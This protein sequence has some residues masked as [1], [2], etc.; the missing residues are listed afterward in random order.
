VGGDRTG[1][2]R[3]GA[4][5]DIRRHA[6]RPHAVGR[7]PL[8]PRRT[9]SQRLLWRGGLAFEGEDSWGHRVPISGDPSAE[10]AKASDLLALSLA[11]CLAYDVV[12]VLEKKR[13]VVRHLEVLVTSEQEDIDPWPFRRITVRFLVTGDVA[14]RAA[15]RALGLA[16]KH[17][18]VM[19]TITPAVVVDASITVIG[20]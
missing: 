12:V 4:P 13:Q 3:A 17:C 14:E 10:G 2:W 7:S 20:V 8:M 11:A 15:A 16:E 19:A 5:P 1:R 6:R 18:P 9:G